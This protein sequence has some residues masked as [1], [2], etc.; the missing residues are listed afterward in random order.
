MK[1]QRKT[2]F[3]SKILTVTSRPRISN[4]GTVVW[5]IKDWKYTTSHFDQFIFFVLQRS[6][7]NVKK[8]LM[9]SIEPLWHY[10]CLLPWFSLQLHTPSWLIDLQL[11][12]KLGVIKKSVDI[13]QCFCEEHKLWFT[14]TLNVICEIGK[15]VAYLLWTI[16]MGF[17]NRRET[18]KPTTMQSSF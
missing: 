2:S 18:S 7:K 1:S 9:R 5:Y 16:I 15:W 17:R 3:P 11:N 4:K 14:C 13:D 6:S 8:H 10:R 12:T